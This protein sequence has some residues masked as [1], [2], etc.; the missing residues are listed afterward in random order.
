MKSPIFTGSFCGERISAEVDGFTLTARIE[1]DEGH[2]APWI[3]EDGH[4]PVSDWT[5]RAKR[6]GERV[7]CEDRGSRRY[8]DYAEAIAIAKRDGWDAEPIGTGTPGEKA[9]RAV[10][11][12]FKRLRSWCNDG[13]TYVGVVVAV[14]R[15]GIVLDANAASLWGI[16]SDCRDYLLEVADQL[17]E[18]A[19]TVGRDALK[20]L[21]VTLPDRMVE[22]YERRAQA[23]RDAGGRID[24]D[25]GLP[26]V[27]VTMSDGSEYFFQEHEASELL[28]EV[29]E[30]I[31]EEDYILA[32]AQGW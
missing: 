21:P 1:P 5:R 30:N 9:A 26:T 6:P 25:H 13:W 32:L 8:Y 2:G 14:G 4:G 22:D 24:I 7:L 12:D 15:N 28:D 16:E 23:E 20:S 19:L 29:P 3:E 17:A 11:A 31:A 18:E 10:E 27:A